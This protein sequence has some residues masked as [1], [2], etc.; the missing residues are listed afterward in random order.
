VGYYRWRGDFGKGG[1][2]IND[3]KP[4]LHFQNLWMIPQKNY[5][6]VKQQNLAKKPSIVLQ[7]WPFLFRNPIWKQIRSKLLFGFEDVVENISNI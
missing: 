2:F 1:Y 7:S 3:A 4:G 5:R 6:E